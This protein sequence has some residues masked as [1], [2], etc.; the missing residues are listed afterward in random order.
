M[1]PAQI[2]RFARVLAEA[3][4]ADPV[5]A[6]L[7]PRLHGRSL[8]AM[9]EHELAGLGAGNRSVD[10]AWDG[11][12]LIGVALWEPPEPRPPSWAERVQQLAARA[13]LGIRRVRVLRRKVAELQ[14]HRPAAPHWYLSDLATTPAARGRGVGSALL[15]S[16]LARIDQAHLPAYLE[17]TSQG[18]RKLYARFGF[19]PVGAIA[20]FPGTDAM[21]MIRPAR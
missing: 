19:E 8:I 9:F 5:V 14:E 11:D 18:S 7:A 2:P 17:S 13:R 10:G 20:G 3:F 4:A 6:Q 15:N 12:D 16:R 1:T 21:A